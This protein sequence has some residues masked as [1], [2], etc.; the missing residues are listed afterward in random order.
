[1][2]YLPR[3]IPVLL[4]SMAATSWCSRPLHQ[5]TWPQ[6]DRVMP[7][8]LLL[9]R[10]TAGL[11][12]CHIHQIRRS[13]RSRRKRQPFVRLGKIQTSTDKPVK[14]PRMELLAVVVA[15]RLKKITRG[16]LSL[17]VNQ[18]L[19]CTDS[20][21]VLRYRL[22]NKDRRFQTFVANRVVM[23]RGHK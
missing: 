7:A 18:S 15:T 8:T 21:C 20:T 13:G 16:E 23:M 3:R 17:P 5:V 6:W 9:R 11:W 12:S 1:M 22:E 10:V 19:F 2:R 14:I 4:A